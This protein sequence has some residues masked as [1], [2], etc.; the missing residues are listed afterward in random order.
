[1]LLLLLLPLAPAAQIGIPDVEEVIDAELN[2][3]FACSGYDIRKF[4][5]TA[6]EVRCGG[7]PGGFQVSLTSGEQSIPVEA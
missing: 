4:V 5:A 7:G 2:Y 1:M 6:L 3:K